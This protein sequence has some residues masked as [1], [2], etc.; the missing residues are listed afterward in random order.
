MRAVAGAQAARPAAASCP[1]A[2][3][4]DWAWEVGFPGVP[5]PDRS[6]NLRTAQGWFLELLRT[7]SRVKMGESRGSCPLLNREWRFWLLLFLPLRV[8]DVY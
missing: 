5:P 2:E 7:V 6:A 3:S 4:G 1:Q 8:H